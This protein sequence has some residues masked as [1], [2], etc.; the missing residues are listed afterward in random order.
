YR[1]LSQ[2]QGNNSRQNSTTK[3][4][5]NTNSLVERQ[6]H[7]QQAREKYTRRDILTVDNIDK[8]QR[9]IEKT[10]L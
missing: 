3:N 9:N 5:K 10:I 2:R 7:R 6:K 4:T 8:E 1:K